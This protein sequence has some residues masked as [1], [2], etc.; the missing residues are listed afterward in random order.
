MIVYK[1]KHELRNSFELGLFV[2]LGRYL[3]I[4]QLALAISDY[5]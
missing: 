1:S 3:V 4:I 5:I 2:R